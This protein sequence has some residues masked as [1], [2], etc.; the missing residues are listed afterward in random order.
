MRHC[1]LLNVNNGVNANGRPDGLLIEHCDA[2]LLTGIRSYFA[3]IEG[4]DAVVQNNTVANSTR[5]HGVR[6]WEFQRL[7]IRNN[8]ITNIA[9][10]IEDPID[11]AKNAINLQAGAY[12]YVDGNTLTGPNSVG[13]LGKKDGLAF[14]HQRS[15]VYVVENNLFRNGTLGVQHGLSDVTIRNNRFEVEGIRCIEV[16]GADAIYARQC[17]NVTIENNTATNPGRRGGF[18]TVGGTVGGIR[19]VGNTYTAPNLTTGSYETACV[20]VN[21]RT[22]NS[23]TTI[24][25]NTWTTGKPLPFANGGVMYVWPKWSDPRG[26]LTPAAWNALPNVTEEAFNIAK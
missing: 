24:T 11:I 9:R 10:P 4:T 13:P 6:G 5:E 26:Y 3:W 23:F 16:D 2:P 20:Y 21:D 25:R 22:N 18:L 12:A 7:L 17:D 15:R 1:T 8:T 14:K 19:L